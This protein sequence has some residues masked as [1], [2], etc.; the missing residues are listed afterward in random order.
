MDKD[1]KSSSPPAS[2][3]LQMFADGT[4]TRRKLYLDGAERK[5]RERRASQR[6]L[7]ERGATGL[8]LKPGE[9]DKTPLTIQAAACCSSFTG[10]YWLLSPI[11]MK[12]GQINKGTILLRLLVQDAAVRTPD[13]PGVSIVFLTIRTGPEPHWM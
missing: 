6:Q 7:E 1:Q 9:P 12:V 11:Q 13:P 3:P 10:Y 8:Q 5:R 4:K 2:T